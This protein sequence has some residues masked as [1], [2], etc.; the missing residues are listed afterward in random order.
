M[1]PDQMRESDEVER[2]REVF[3]FSKLLNLSE[4]EKFSCLSKFLWD[5]KFMNY[6]S[7]LYC[8]F[9]TLTHL[10][11]VNFQSDFRPSV[12]TCLK[13]R[14]RYSSSDTVPLQPCY[15]VKAICMSRVAGGGS[16]SGKLVVT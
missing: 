5:G 7:V 9:V 4:S 16:V 13:N 11:R 15:I 1:I 14:T 6:K 8:Y 12:A 10:V 2:L 3:F